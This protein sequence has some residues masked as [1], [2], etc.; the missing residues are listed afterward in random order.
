[1]KL[2]TTIK[3]DAFYVKG[4]NIGT[5]LVERIRK[6]FYVALLDPLDAFMVDIFASVRI[7]ES[8]MKLAAQ[9]FGDEIS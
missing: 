6:L 9:R 3:I 2:A 4:N 1:M 7:K 5:V 8:L